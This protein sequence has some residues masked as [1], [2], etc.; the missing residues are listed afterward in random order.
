MK[1]LKLSFG[2]I[3]SSASA[4]GARRIIVSAR[5]SIV[6]TSPRAWR[7]GLP[8]WR[9]MSSATASFIARNAATNSVQA[10]MRTA[11]GVSRH[12]C[13]AARIF[14]RIESSS[15]SEVGSI[16]RST[17]SVA[18]LMR[19]QLEV[20][21][22]FYQLSWYRARRSAWVQ[23]R[24]FVLWQESSNALPDSATRLSSGTL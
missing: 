12:A 15:A 23:G 7:M 10:A 4:S 24:I 17:S 2:G 22:M 1:R 18:G 3:G 19:V 6:S 8:I 9:V 20:V 14:T 13:W 5:V 16:V 21:D 11:S